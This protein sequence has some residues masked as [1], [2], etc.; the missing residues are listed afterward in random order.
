MAHDAKSRPSSPTP[1][2]TK[3]NSAPGKTRRDSFYV[4]QLGSDE[5]QITIK[6]HTK[7]PDQSESLKKIKYRDVLKHL[8]ALLEYEHKYRI[9]IPLARTVSQCG[10]ARTEL[11]MWCAI[12][13]NRWLTTREKHQHRV[14][15]DKMWTDRVYSVY[16]TEC[17]VKEV[18][19]RCETG[20]VTGSPLEI[21]Q[22]I[23][24]CMYRVWEWMNELRVACKVWSTE[25]CEVSLTKNLRGKPAKRRLGNV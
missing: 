23:K 12:V 18:W 15:D 13:V 5:N 2:L 6:Y 21:D 1:T 19:V 9:K 24:T 20:E 14:K 25:V 17:V 4:R 3:R 16:C 8:E 11:E 7:A 10:S 22:T